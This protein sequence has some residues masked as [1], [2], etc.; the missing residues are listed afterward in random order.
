MYDYWVTTF[1]PVIKKARWTQQFSESL[2]LSTVGLQLQ[3]PFLQQVLLQICIFLLPFHI[4]QSGIICLLLVPCL[5]SL[6]P[7][8]LSH[9]PLF[10]RRLSLLVLSCCCWFWFCK[11]WNPIKKPVRNKRNYK[12]S[13]PNLPLLI[14]FFSCKLFHHCYCYAVFVALRLVLLCCAGWTLF[15]LLLVFILYR[16]WGSFCKVQKRTKNCIWLELQ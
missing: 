7:A 14:L 16:N 2:A 4:G 13:F 12:Q 10:V 6:S 1:I 9:C 8:C 5:L 3:Q 11:R 15:L